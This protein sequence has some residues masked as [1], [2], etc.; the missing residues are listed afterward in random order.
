M[1]P[2]QLTGIDQPLAP[3]V[4]GTMTFGDNTER[5]GGRRDDRALP[6]RRRQRHRHRQRLRRRPQRIHARRPAPRTPG[7]G[8]AGH[9]GRHPASRRRRRPAAVDRRDPPLRRRPAS[10]GSAPTTSTCCTCT[11]PTAP[12]RSPRRSPRSE[13][14]L[15]AGAIRAWGVSNFAAWQIAE[16]RRA[17]A[18]HGVPDPVIAQQVY[19]VVA[20]RLDDEYAE[21]AA[22]HRAAHRRLQPARRRP[23]HRQALPD[24]Q[25][26]DT[27]RFGDSR[28]GGMYRDRYWNDTVFDAV[29]D[30]TNARRPG[31]TD[32]RRTRAALDHRPARRGRRHSSA[33][34]DRR[35]SAPTSPQSPTGR[36]R[37]TSPTPSPRSPPGYADRCRPTT[38]DPPGRPEHAR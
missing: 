27:G 16:L 4:L 13:Q 26:P 18:D 9:Q 7:P 1:H 20:T 28:L 8:R 32:N 31:R 34:P 35:T 12:P 19:N 38:G 3:V 11:N 5:G 37:P 2:L 36:S 24:Q 23:A 15:D 10:A 14:L 22:Q 30:L 29:T 17:A 33:A 21:Y 25:T 6:G